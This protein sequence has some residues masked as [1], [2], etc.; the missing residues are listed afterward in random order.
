MSQCSPIM[1]SG[2]SRCGMLCVIRSAWPPVSASGHASCTQL[3][4]P[5]RAVRIQA[6]SCRLLA[7][8]P[9][10]CPFLD[11]NTL[12]AQS[13]QHKHEVI[14]KCWWIEIGAHCGFTSAPTSTPALLNSIL[15]LH[16][17]SP[18]FV[19]RTLKEPD[20]T[21]NDRFRT[22]GS[23]HGP[24]S[25]QVRAPVCSLRQKLCCGGGAP[26]RWPG[27]NHFL[28]YFCVQDLSTP[29]VVVDGAPRHRGWH[30]RRPYS[31]A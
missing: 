24:P 8:T 6:Y 29:A 2:S 12:S 23:K 21:R 16:A 15:R 11:R 30:S 7:M 28:G 17:R 26:T 18:S 20:A 10:I 31:A 3:G 9:M 1:S 13:K 25:D 27:A 14:Y 5:T 19:G 4:R 22:N